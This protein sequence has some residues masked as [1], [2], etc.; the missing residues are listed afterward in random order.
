MSGWYRSVRVWARPTRTILARGQSIPRY[1]RRDRDASLHERLR[2]AS[3]EGGFLV[4]VGDSSVGKTRSLYE[5]LLKVLPEW[6]VLLV[7]TRR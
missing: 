5:A 4:I 7:G 6:H 3:R 2:A 1:I